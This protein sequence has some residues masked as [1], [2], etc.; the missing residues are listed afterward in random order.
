MVLF[1]VPRACP[2][3]HRPCQAQR[4]VLPLLW[5]LLFPLVLCC[6]PPSNG[7]CSLLLK[8]T[9]GQRKHLYT[10][11]PYKF[12][13]GRPIPIQKQLSFC[14]IKVTPWPIPL[15]TKPLGWEADTSLLGHL[16][17]EE[18]PF[19]TSSL[20]TW[21]GMSSLS[22]SGVHG[23]YRIPLAVQIFPVNPPPKFSL[24]SFIFL[25]WI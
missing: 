13:E 1:L 2:P 11:C 18:R 21:R 14:T 9:P 22:P 4:M 8:T 5:V 3:Q 19:W 16:H 24:G 12:W 20:L 25:I 15:F 10:F 6:P 7:L 23:F 17:C